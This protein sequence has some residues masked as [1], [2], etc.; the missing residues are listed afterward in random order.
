MTVNKKVINI[1]CAPDFL[2]F[3]EK[4]NWKDLDDFNIEN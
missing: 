3:N 4:K 1:S 2:L